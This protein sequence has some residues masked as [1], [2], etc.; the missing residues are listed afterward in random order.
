MSFCLCITGILSPPQYI[1]SLQTKHRLG[2]FDL[3]AQ[4]AR[5]QATSLILF[6]PIVDSVI[7]SYWVWD[8][9]LTS[10]ALVR[11]RG[12]RGWG[13]EGGMNQVGLGSIVIF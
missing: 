6:A 10:G 13:D 3:L 12:W 4:T 7:T 5:M 9:P 8:Y 11:R 2:A 1:G